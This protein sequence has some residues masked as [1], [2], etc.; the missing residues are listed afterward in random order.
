MMS[1]GSVIDICIGAKRG[2]ALMSVSE[3]RAV[4]GKGLEGDRNFKRRGAKPDEELTLIEIEAIED[5]RRTSGKDFSPADA[6]RNVVTRGVSLN[7]L[8]GREF[9]VG[10]VRVRGLELCEPCS[11]L[12]RLTGHK[13]IVRGMLHRCGLRA[14]ILLDGVI[15]V[16][17][18][19]KA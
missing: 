16:G 17:D 3:V 19:V 9:Q 6:R 12:A 14:Q 15:R 18:E 2:G 1:N 13:D 10:S 4:A 7:E 8:V 11:H 5:Y